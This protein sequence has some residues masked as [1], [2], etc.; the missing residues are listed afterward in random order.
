MKQQRALISAACLLLASCG[1]AAD[2]TQLMEARE[3]FL[4]GNA[5]YEASLKLERAAEAGDREAFKAA[6]MRAED[7]LAYWQRAAATRADWPAARRNVERA[8][9]RVEALRESK[10]DSGKKKRDPKKKDEPEKEDPEAMKAPPRRVATKELAAD[11]VLG[12]L[13]LLE[14]REQARRALRKAARAKRSADVERDW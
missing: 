4:K 10:R 1:G 12:V 14:K 8:L 11:R 5:A 2:R 9:L 7:A 3:T 6:V 13:D